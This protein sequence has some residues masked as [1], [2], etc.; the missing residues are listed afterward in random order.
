MQG[1]SYGKGTLALGADIPFLQNNND[2]A[3][4]ARSLAATLGPSLEFKLFKYQRS[5]VHPSSEL[6][7]NKKKKEKKRELLTPKNP[8]LVR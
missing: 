7:Y 8:H 1:L 5:R 6:F 2:N 4:F 3:F